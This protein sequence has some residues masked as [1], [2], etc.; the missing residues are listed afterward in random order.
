V[1]NLTE[2]DFARP[3]EIVLGDDK[4][5]VLELTEV[6]ALL[7]P[8]V[9]RQAALNRSDGEVRRI[10]YY[11]E[12]M[13][14]DFEKGQIRYEI[15]FQFHTELVAAAHNTILLHLMS[16]IYQWVSYS[17]RIH[18]EKVFIRKEDQFI[19][20]NHHLRIFKAIQDRDPD[21]AEAAMKE[22]LLYVV[23]E[24]KKWSSAHRDVPAGPEAPTQPKSD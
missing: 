15:D 9:A 1:K 10:N 7:E 23:D 12:E 6:R 14:N 3:M 20:F 21:A 22:H 8:W 18:R 5:R 2:R 24:F 13:E 16:S 17:I 11:L 19:I 4:Q